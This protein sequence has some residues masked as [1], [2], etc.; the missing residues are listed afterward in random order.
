M[1]EK[2]ISEL[3]YMTHGVQIIS[4]IGSILVL[5]SYLCRGERNIR[6]VN[7]I[8]SVFCI[9]YSLITMQWSNLILNII[10]IGVNGYHL[11]NDKKTN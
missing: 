10:L 6:L 5:S 3:I 11:L 9:I 4:L 8:A 7:V 1:K 2:L